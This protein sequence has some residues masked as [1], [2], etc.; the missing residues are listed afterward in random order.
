MKLASG[1][2]ASVKRYITK[3]QSPL[4]H[5]LRQERARIRRLES[6]M[7][8]IRALNDVIEREEKYT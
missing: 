7:Q 8:E 5:E 4:T 3:T 1:G 2:D 6:E